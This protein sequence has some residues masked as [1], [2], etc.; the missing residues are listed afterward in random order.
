MS[1]DE[2][3]G[4]GCGVYD[5]HTVAVVMYVDHARSMRVACKTTK[6]RYIR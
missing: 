1:L 2:S 5:M 6:L 4:G 3:E